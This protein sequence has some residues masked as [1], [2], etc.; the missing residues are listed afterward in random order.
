MKS[1][2]SQRA[3]RTRVLPFL[4]APALVLAAA[5]SSSGD[6]GGPLTAAS[7]VQDL[8][9]DP[10]GET[11]TVSLT[12]FDGQIQAGD[13]EASGGQNAVHVDVLHGEARVRFD[14][15]V[16]AGDSIRFVGVDG[17]SSDWLTV[18]SSDERAPRMAVLDATQDTSDQL[19]GGDEVRAAFALGPRV[20]EAEVLD[21][22]NWSVVVEG[23]PLDMTGSTV[24]FDV[25][26]QV[27]TLTLGELANLHRNFELAVDLTAVNGRDLDPA[28]VAGIATGDT[29]PPSL[30][31]ATPVVQMLD[32]GAQG[33]EFGRRIRIDFDEPMSPVF[34][35]APGNFG[36][37]DHVSAIGVTAVT[38][39]VVDPADNSALFV[40]FS[41]PV[42][43]GLDRLEINGVV[44]AHGNPV[45]PQNVDITA[46]ST[47]VNGFTS[48]AL[49][50]LE[51]QGNDRFVAV[52]DQA[53]DPD[54]AALATTWTLDI[55]GNPF[56]LTTAE[57]DYDLGAKTLTIDLGVDVPNG[58][59]GDLSAVA[60]VDVD[61]EA[62]A[63]AAP[64]TLA[65][66]DAAGPEVA[67]VLQNRAAA[68]AGNFI[69]VTFTEDVDVVTGTD[70]ANYGLNPAVVVQQATMIEGR[71]VRLE[72]ASAVL[73]GTSTI[74]VGG[75]ISDPAGN[76]ATGALGPLQ[77]ASTDSTP[78]AIGGLS[79]SAEEGLANDEVVVLFTDLM[80]EDDVRDLAR[81]SLE[82]PAGTPLD[83]TGCT[84][85][86]SPAGSIV[87]L[88]LDGPAAPALLIG[89][90]VV[91][92]VT[93]VRDIGGN[94]SLGSPFSAVVTGESTR[95]TVE[96][97]TIGGGPGVVTVRFS[98]PCRDVAELFDPVNQ[99]LAPRFGLVDTV[100]GT[101]ETPVAATE[102]DSGQ[103]VQLSFGVLIDPAFVFDV[104]GVRDLAGNVMFPVAGV[105]LVA[106][107]TSEPALAAPTVTATAGTANDVVVIEFATPMSAWRLAEPAA[108]QL[109]EQPSGATIDLEGALFDFDGDR[110]LTVTFGP[111]A[112]IDLEAGSTYDLTVL[113][114]GT[115]GL[116]TRQG[117]T[118]TLDD[119]SA[120]LAVG[121]DIASGPTGA[122]TRAFVDPVDPAAVIV[123]FDETVRAAEAL[124]AG[125]YAVQ[126]GATALTVASVTD[127]AVRATFPAPVGLGAIIDVT[128]NA[129]VDTAGNPA[130]GTLSVAVLADS[131]APTIAATT[132]QIAEGA[133]G[134]LL[135][136]QFSEEVDPAV[137]LDAASYTV[138]FGGQ[139]ARVSGSWY[140]SQTSS[141]LLLIEDVSDGAT[142]DVTIA[143]VVDLAGNPAD[144]GALQ[145]S[146]LASGDST[147]PFMDSAYLN[148]YEDEVG[149]T[150]DVHLNEDVRAL[151]ATVPGSW[152]S[153]DGRTVTGVTQIAGDT[154]QL[155]FDGPVTAGATLTLA[156]GVT[157]Y[158]RNE[159]G[160]LTVDVTE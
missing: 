92:T 158:A 118:L 68:A 122:G 17:V 56:D 22:S 77:I 107:D 75:A 76:A 117:V 145:G 125:E 62:F 150:V 142:V 35:A 151:V 128:A 153:S 102:I 143:G 136:V 114:S 104:S 88:T 58:T 51:G 100:M 105:P 45:A 32:P 152:S 44:D 67:A 16:P 20:I 78:P 80:F 82:S 37:L 5:C 133:G 111:G 74:T 97:V 95:P 138:T 108:Y 115:D 79:A 15:R 8:L 124:V 72:L 90:D 85:G 27:A 110:T 53:I 61:G 87:T 11:V 39:V 52:L 137:V 86:A 57:L 81:W 46:G 33:E 141:V 160:V 30:D 70:T 89:D 135:T 41:R 36:V 12:G 50:T 147:P 119:T 130:S 10:D 4:C 60:A 38:R 40:D 26:T 113:A 101:T 47:V 59:T 96:T 48:V 34:G 149:A 140:D 7:A 2:H 121:G 55:S 155:T 93:G 9:V 154:F 24:A 3:A 159:A 83:I 18:A 63:G 64:Q 29:T 94:A 139:T 157:D 43:P 1:T 73:P 28:P 49:E 71:V 99:P 31:G 156:A 54:T 6:E 69:D 84:V 112:G 129:A 66:G 132:V 120:G 91:L 134:D 146:A 98:E 42:V 13:V 123:V 144:G 126:G 25:A 23:T 103:G 106:E 19:L 14:A 65:A 21:I 109:V 127:R 116:R 148:L 131:T